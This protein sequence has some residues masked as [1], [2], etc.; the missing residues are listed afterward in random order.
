MGRGKKTRIIKIK[1]N[2]KAQ[3]SPLVMESG[4]RNMG[5][6]CLWNPESWAPESR[7]Q[8]KKSGIPL[9]IRLKNPSSTDKD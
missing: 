4:F 9:K 2:Q 8:R 7:K 6:V 5:N 3:M 1:G